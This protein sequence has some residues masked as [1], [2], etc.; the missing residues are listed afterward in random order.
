MP[1][2]LNISQSDFD[3]Q[4]R[5]I[6]NNPRGQ[7]PDIYQT[8][9]NIIQ[10]IRQD[11]DKALLTYTRQFDDK[12]ATLKNIK[13]T[14]QELDDATNS[15]D[16]SLKNALKLA[17]DRI[18]A[19]HKKLLPEHIYY[20]DD[21]GTQ[22]GIRYTPIDSVGVYIPGG[23]ANYPSSVLMNIIPAKI[24]GVGRIVAVV[25]APNGII[26]PLVL[27]ALNLTPRKSCCKC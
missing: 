5:I 8:V 12:N 10:N 15:I 27:Y 4:L 24:A 3:N 20:T 19:F 1:I 14:Q 26:H 7:S 16:D 11:G 13:V 22:L 21:T 9:H 17:Y 2:I 23:T 18:F 6:L 25:P